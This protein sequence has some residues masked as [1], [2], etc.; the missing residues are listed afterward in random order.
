[1]T[2]SPLL[3]SVAES[4]VIFL[5]MDQLGCFRASAKVTFSKS[6]R[7]F[8]RKGPPE[9]VNNIRSMAF[10]WALSPCQD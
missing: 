10:P 3:T 6:F 4:T 1:M 5:P 2:S 7:D 8:P 9:A